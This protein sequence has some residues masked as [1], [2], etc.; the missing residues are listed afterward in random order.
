MLHCKT[1]H[2]QQKTFNATASEQNPCH[3][4]NTTNIQTRQT[5]GTKW[6]KKHNKNLE[7][8][9]QKSSNYQNIQNNFLEMLFLQE[10]S[11]REALPWY[12]ADSKRKSTRQLPRTAKK[13][14][15]ITITPLPALPIT[16]GSS[17]LLQLSLK[18]SSPGA[19]SPSV[20]ELPMAEVA[21]HIG[22]E[23]VTFHLPVLLRWPEPTP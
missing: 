11:W 6:E 2:Q 14:G 22:P 5:R 9:T 7:V 23:A 16:L 8:F 19:E 12:R 1:E 10:Y 21:R 3:L 15:G 13:K 4:P 18:V 17:W 20:T